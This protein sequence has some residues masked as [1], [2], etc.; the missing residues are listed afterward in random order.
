MEGV[1]TWFNDCQSKSDVNLRQ[2]RPALCRCHSL[3]KPGPVL[4]LCCFAA[5]CWLFAGCLLVVCWLFVV[6]CSYVCSLIL[7]CSCPVY[8]GSLAAGHALLLRI[9]PQATDVALRAPGG[10]RDRA[11]LTELTLRGAQG[12]LK[13]TRG[14][15]QNAFVRFVCNILFAL[16]VYFVN[17][18]MYNIS[19]IYFYIDIQYCMNM[20]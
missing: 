10:R 13:G 9:L 8:R 1:R 14:T 7:V 16:F 19:Y 3:V 17:L 2:P 11:G 20:K 15:L 12:V 18:G 6:V 4:G 5:V